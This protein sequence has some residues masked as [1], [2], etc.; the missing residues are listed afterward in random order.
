MTD[1]DRGRGG[2]EPVGGLIRKLFEE[3]GIA[4]RVE[5]SRTAARWHE[6][7]GP[8]ISE[9][10]GDVRVR[11]RALFVEVRSAPWLTELSLLRHRLLEK[12]NEGREDGRIEKI[13]FLQADGPGTGSAGGREGRESHPADHRR[14]RGE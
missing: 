5:R 12:L 3:K 13:V 6:I 9:Y 10:T 2:P 8:R 4:G 14:D 7:A 11:G 1:G